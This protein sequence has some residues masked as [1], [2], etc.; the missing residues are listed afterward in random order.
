[1]SEKFIV[2]EEGLCRS[3]EELLKSR[4]FA[5]FLSFFNEARLNK[6]LDNSESWMVE[7]PKVVMPEL[8]TLKDVADDPQFAEAV[9][10]FYQQSE[11]GKKHPYES[12]KELLKSRHFPV[13]LKDFNLDRRS[14]A[15]DD[16]LELQDRERHR[17]EESKASMPK[18]VT[19]E[20]VAHDPKLAEEVYDFYCQSN[21]EIRG[22]AADVANFNQLAVETLDH[23]RH[24]L[25]EVLDDEDL[26][27][28]PDWILL[29][30][31]DCEKNLPIRVVREME[32]AY[33]DIWVRL[34][35]YPSE[36]EASRELVSMMMNNFYLNY[37][38]HR[39]FETE[40][41]EKRDDASER[42]K[43]KRWE[44]IFAE[45]DE[46]LEEKGLLAEEAKKKK[47]KTE[48]DLYLFPVFLEMLKRGYKIYPDLF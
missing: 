47:N 48:R 8:V 18:K 37:I 46:I 38:A 10:N 24:E 30:L 9:Y 17:I 11:T 25:V 21:V 16:A 33:Q 32:W 15:I 5:Q 20:Q 13:I 27:K 23:V 12:L 2:E 40:G 35:D 14:K 42:M 29:A 43:S 34:S 41:D 36:I 4:R 44:E 45:V 39:Y 1:M 19:P 28:T 31:P 3:P 26:T 6:V 22:S 7:R